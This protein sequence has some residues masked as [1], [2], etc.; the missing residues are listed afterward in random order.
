VSRSVAG[1]GWRPSLP[2]HRDLIADTA[3][4]AI[5]PQVDPRD[6]MPPPY[7]QGQLGSCTANVIA[8][9]IEYDRALSGDTMAGTPS[10]LDIYY[11]ERLLEGTVGEDAGAFGRDGFKFAHKTGVIPEACWPYEVADFARAPPAEPAQRY[12]IGAYAAVPRSLAAIKQVL[13]NRQTIAFGFS[14]YESFE[15]DALA[16]TGVMAAPAP[17]ER[18]IGGHAVLMV[19]Y[20]RDHPD[21][22]LCRNSWGAQWGMAGYFLMSLAVVLDAGMCTDF[23]TIKRPAGA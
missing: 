1:L 23:R 12:R 20:L 9:A 7:A 17:G 18:M 6:E 21:H 5:L 10:R 11:G 2:D 19:G 22:V 8:A 16:R 13:S 3:T 4:L 15:G 14:V